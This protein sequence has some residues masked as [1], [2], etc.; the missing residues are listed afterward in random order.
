ML[1]ATLG[2]AIP[3][4]PWRLVRLIDP[5][6][7]DEEKHSTA[8]EFCELPHAVWILD[9]VIDFGPKPIPSKNF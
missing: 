5:R 7:D 6:L 8:V 4:I 2:C 9:L 3:T 1:V